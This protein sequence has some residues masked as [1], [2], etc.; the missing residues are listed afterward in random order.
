MMRN[1]KINPLNALDIRKSTF[2]AKHFTYVTVEKFTPNLLLNLDEWIFDNLNGRYYIGPS[3]GL[4]NNSIAYVTKIGF[5][6]EK[7][8]SFFKIACPHI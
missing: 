7:E 2:P 5:E 6:N 8:I 3:L 4:I 1:G